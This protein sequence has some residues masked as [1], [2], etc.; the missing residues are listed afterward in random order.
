[1]AGEVHDAPNQQVV[2]PD[3]SHPSDEGKG[4]SKHKRQKDEPTVKETKDAG[5]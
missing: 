5:K 2:R 1:M 3:G 4:G